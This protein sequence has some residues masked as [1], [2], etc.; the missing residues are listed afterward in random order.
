MA[1]LLRIYDRVWTVQFEQLRLLLGA[2]FLLFL[3]PK[4]KPQ[5]VPFDYPG[6]SAYLMLQR[7][8]A[9]DLPADGTWPPSQFRAREVEAL[10]RYLDLTSD[11]M[12]L[13]CRY[14]TGVSDYSV[15]TL[16]T[17]SG[18]REWSRDR[19][20]T[21]E[22]SLAS[23]IGFSKRLSVFF[24]SRATND[25][26]GLPGFT[27]WTMSIAR[28]PFRAAETDYMFF[29]FHGSLGHV[30]FGRIRSGWTGGGPHS[31]VLAAEGPPLDGFSGSLRYHDFT[32]RF[33]AGYLESLQSNVATLPIH[34]YFAGHYLT[35]RKGGL[36]LTLAETMLY[37]GKARPFDFSYAIPLTTFFES[38]VNHR[39]NQP[40]NEIDNAFIHFSFR[41]SLSGV[42]SVYGAFLVDEL[43]IDPKD[44]RKIPDA[45]ASRWALNVPLSRS[46]IVWGIHAEYVH[47]DAWT[48]RYEDG[49]GN[50]QARGFPLGWWQGSDLNSYEIELDHLDRKGQVFSLSLSQI[51]QGE[52][53]LRL[54]LYEGK[55]LTLKLPSPSGIVSRTTRLLLKLLIR[56]WDRFWLRATLGYEWQN[57]VGHMPR[58]TKDSWLV[59]GSLMVPFGFGFYGRRASSEGL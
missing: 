28:G 56:P 41:Y 11:P 32:L 47:V 22:L 24:R 16:S 51:E 13:L 43:Q 27:G 35:Y 10:V 4:A 30:D 17:H 53:D 38:D 59:G 48:Y 5:G 2:L 3:V 45:L 39:F 9:L 21:L 23:H 19:G 42:L 18:F 52:Q 8:A 46:R 7:Y 14:Q 50:Y 6:L 26:A 12:F 20:N 34:R 58:I 31:L 37:A 33:V 15:L 25:A 54:H 55:E 44:R 36:L 29:R 1:R 49:L 40:G 57:N